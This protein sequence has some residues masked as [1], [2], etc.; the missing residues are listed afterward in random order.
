MSASKT[1]KPI[2][3]AGYLIALFIVGMLCG[4]GVAMLEAV[5]G[6]GWLSSRT[7]LI[8][9]FVVA[10]ILVVSAFWLGARWMKSIDEAAQEAHKWSWYWG[11]SVGLAAGMVL[12]F[13]GSLPMGA[14]LQVAS[15]FDGRTDPAAYMAT[16]AVGIV[17]LMM[18][19]YLLAWALWWFQR[20]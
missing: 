18:I 7:G 12:I 16:G 9:I 13:V 1:T 8:A 6:T 20:R 15:W 11:G 2:K 19:G 3:P 4:A 17:G 10:A 14:S 5:T